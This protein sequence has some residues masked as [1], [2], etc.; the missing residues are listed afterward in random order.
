VNCK[1]TDHFPD[2][3]KGS[4]RLYF[5]AQCPSDTLPPKLLSRTNIVTEFGYWYTM[6]S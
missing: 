3:D 6:K 2:G 4:K 5:I 1:Q